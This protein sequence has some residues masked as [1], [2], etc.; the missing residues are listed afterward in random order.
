MLWIGVPLALYWIYR[1]Y[2]KR[3]QAREVRVAS[4][5]ELSGRSDVR[6]FDR[7]TAERVLGEEAGNP[8][9]VLYV[10]CR[11]AD[12]GAVYLIDQLI[13]RG[14]DETK[15]QLSCV[16]VLYDTELPHFVLAPKSLGDNLG[17]L[18]FRIAGPGRIWLEA[19]SGIGESWQLLGH[20]EEK[21][22]E[23]F[24][25][26]LGRMLC[27]TDTKRFYAA[28]D[29]LIYAIEG[30]E[31]WSAADLAGFMNRAAAIGDQIAAV[32]TRGGF[33]ASARS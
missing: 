18:G 1:R 33:K 25:N 3:R 5:S 21:L 4:A 20:D 32:T 26:G 16:V 7:S 6:S 13:G 31:P 8:L 9:E 2:R 19:S 14:E 27:A 30:N 23:L 15:L 22:R 10:L 29:R 24:A 11:K 28:D 17:P 12:W